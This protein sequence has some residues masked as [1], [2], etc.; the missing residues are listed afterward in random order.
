MA[1]LCANAGSGLK[2]LTRLVGQ[3]LRDENGLVRVAAVE[4]LI[5]LVLGD[6]RPWSEDHL[7]DLLRDWL[8]SLAVADTPAGHPLRIILRDRL[9][10]ACAAA[11][12]HA[13][14]EREAAAAARATQPA[15]GAEEKRRLEDLDPDMFTEIGYPRR[16]RLPRPD[17]PSEITSETM[18][19]LFALLGADLGDQGAATLRRV[20]K[21]YPWQ[22]GPAVEELLTGR[23]SPPMV[24]G[25]WPK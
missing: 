5:H 16:R 20:A 19:E 18:V 9:L 17:I 13:Q 4:P 12:R 1:E 23:R 2:R 15:E 8:R 11:D 24:V 25:S 14:L 3:R 22:L 7:L 21:G 10:A 6:D